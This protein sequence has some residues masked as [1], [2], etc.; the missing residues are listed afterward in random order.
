MKEE[1]LLKEKLPS[2]SWDQKGLINLSASFWQIH[3]TFSNNQALP[4]E[5]L[6]LF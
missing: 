2:G 5:N 3:D 1:E 6:L 4:M